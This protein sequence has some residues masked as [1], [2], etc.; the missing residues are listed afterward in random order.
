MIFHF[1]DDSPSSSP[2]E[3]DANFSGSESSP[4]PPPVLFCQCGKCPDLAAFSQYKFCQ[5]VDKAKEQCTQKG[6]NK[7]VKKKWFENLLLGLDCFSDSTKLDKRLDEVF[8]NEWWDFPYQCVSRMYWR[9]FCSHTVT[10]WAWL[11]LTLQ[12]IGELGC[13]YKTTHILVK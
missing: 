1:R 2:E 8:I 12:R 9:L 11:I 5:S 7:L 13:V 3:L 4:P 10:H 6:I